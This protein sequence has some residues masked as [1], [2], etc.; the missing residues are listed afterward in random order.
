MKEL[1]LSIAVINCGELF[2]QLLFGSLRM[3]GV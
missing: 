3:A 2:V 1:I